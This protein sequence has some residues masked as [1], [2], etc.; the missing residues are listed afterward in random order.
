[1]EPVIAAVAA[2]L[3]ESDRD[4]LAAVLPGPLGGA[5]KIRGQALLPIAALP[6]SPR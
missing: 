5:G 1:V 4:R 6:W 3:E 2:S